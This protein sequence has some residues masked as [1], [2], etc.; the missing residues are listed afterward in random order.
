MDEAAHQ[1]ATTGT[2]TMPVARPELLKAKTDSLLE[3]VE[4]RDRASYMRAV[5]GLGAIPVVTCLGPGRCMFPRLGADQRVC[6]FCLR[7]PDGFGVDVAEVARK[8]VVG[9]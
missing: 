5:Q 1:G 4:V 3:A 9:N 7:L 6:S 8:F 2:Q